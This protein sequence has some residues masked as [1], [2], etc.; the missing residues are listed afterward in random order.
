MA[1]NAQL[2][3]AL[4]FYLIDEIDEGNL[5]VTYRFIT[6]DLNVNDGVMLNNELES[7]KVID[8]D[9]LCYDPFIFYESEDDDGIDDISNYYNDCFS[10]LIPSRYTSDYEVN[11]LECFKIA[12]FNIASIP[13]HFE[14]HVDTHDDNI[15]QID[16]IS[17]CETRLNSTL[18]NVY[19]IPAYSAFHNGRNTHGGGV[20]VYVKDC[21]SPTL[22]E[23]LCATDNYME[24]IAVELSMGRMKN[25]VLSLY[26]PPKSDFRTFLAKLE[27][28]LLWSRQKSYSKLYV[29]GDLNINMLKKDNQSLQLFNLMTSFHLFCTTTKP[30][31]IDVNRGSATLID[32]IWSTDVENNVKN[33]IIFD[34]TSDHFP[35]LS[36]FHINRTMGKSM[37]IKKRKITERGKNLFLDE[38]SRV[39]WVVVYNSLNVNMAYKAFFDSFW[40]IYAKYFPVVESKIKNNK[41]LPYLTQEIKAMFKE[42]KRLHRLA[43][44]WPITFKE[45]YINY[46]DSVSTKV[47]QCR[48]QYFKS[49]LQENS[50]NP[51]STWATINEVLGRKG[52]V[53]NI[54][55]ETNNSNM[56]E[57]DFINDYFVTSAESLQH[58]NSGGVPFETFMNPPQ[59]QS[60]YLKPISEEELTKYI[61]SIKTKAC[62]IDEVSPVI[63][64]LCAQ[65]IVQPLAHI[66]NLSFKTGVFPSTLKEAKIIPVHKKGKKSK[67]ENKRPVSILSVFS[68]VFEFSIFSS[69]SY[70]FL[71][72]P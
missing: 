37:T 2:L 29:I 21:F 45:M 54:P 47:K 31:R 67:V 71:V 43:K 16:V 40:T 44:K 34:D 49:K 60:L 32:H 63:V 18:A 39:D 3:E 42:K 48:D 70:V 5:N 57:P 51:K 20:S 61:L 15:K 4:P 59:Q 68:K 38:I 56:T 33:C 6:N 7:S 58:D 72:K 65:H 50:G 11:E 64:K 35:I 27:T 22:V 30:T 62:G 69:L 12:S 10:N 28:M 52:F 36:L 13:L 23:N 66:I 14:M 8:L 46:R 25:L 53:S 17:F 19:K 24:S 1:V 26:R 9:A 55:I 41:K